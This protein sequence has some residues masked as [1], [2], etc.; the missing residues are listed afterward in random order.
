MN[1]STLARAFPSLRIVI[2]LF[3]KPDLMNKQWDDWL[4]GMQNAAAASLLV[5]LE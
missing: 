4:S 3:A 2:G 1:I 5:H